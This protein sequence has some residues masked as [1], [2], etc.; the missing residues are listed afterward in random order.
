M[1]IRPKE[2]R[3]ICLVQRKA[4]TF[5]RHFHLEPGTVLGTGGVTVNKMRLCSQLTQTE[6]FSLVMHSLHWPYMYWKIFFRV[7]LKLCR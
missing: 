4:T 1:K 3:C 2:D 7:Y 5:A 6:L